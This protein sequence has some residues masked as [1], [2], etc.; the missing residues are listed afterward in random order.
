MRQLVE[1]HDHLDAFA[2][3]DARL[4]TVCQK[5]SDP[6]NLPRIADL[7]GE[8]IDVRADPDQLTVEELPLF[9]AYLVDPSGTLRLE[10]PGIKGARARTDVILSELA[11]LRGLASP[12][13]QD[14]RGVAWQREAAPDPSLRADQ[15]LAVHWAFSHDR[16]RPG[17]SLRLFVLPRLAPGWRVRAPDDRG[18]EGPSRFTIE[19]STPPGLSLVEPL[20]L[21]VSTIEVLPDGGSRRVFEGDIPIAAIDFVAADG[22]L[23]AGPQAVL[24]TISYQPWLD[25]VTRDPVE[26]SFRLPIR[27]GAPGEVRGQ[28]YGW[29]RW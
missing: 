17:D 23:P 26:R 20:R 27:F 8:G 9:G 18:A 24:V 19:L 10:L 5:E 28:L 6:A 29:E 1:L 11:R 22:A 3:L 13:V 12:Q 14:T 7:V 2:A 21:P 4:V 16:V 25:D 15:V